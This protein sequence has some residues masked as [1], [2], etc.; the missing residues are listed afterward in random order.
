[1]FSETLG[2]PILFYFNL[3]DS[4]KSIFGVFIGRYWG[5]CPW[6]I[7]NLVLVPRTCGICNACCCCVLS[8]SFSV[9]SQCCQSWYTWSISTNERISNGDRHT[10]YPPPYTS[11][12]TDA[13]R[14]RIPYFNYFHP[15]DNKVAVDTLL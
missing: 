9:Q 7:V 5:K 12:G 14:E 2:G 6:F 13:D 8:P 3:R 4:T 1:M 10:R 11:P 15:S